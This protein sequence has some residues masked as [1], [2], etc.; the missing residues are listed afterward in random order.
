MHKSWGFGQVKTVDVVLGKMTVDFVGR[1][2]HAIDLAFAPKILTPISKDHIEARK[3]T[4]MENLKQLAALH[5]YQVIKVIIDSYDNLATSEK[6]QEVLVP[7]VIDKDDYKKWWETARR[8]MKK[9]GHFK[10]PTKKSEPIEYQDQD[11]PLQDRLLNEFNN[12]RGLKARL[13]VASE[14]TKSARD[15]EDVSVVAEKTLGKLNEEIR[16]HARTKPGLALEALMVRGDFAKALGAELAEDKFAGGQVGHQQQQQRPT[17]LFLGDAAGTEDQREEQHQRQLDHRED[18]EQ[19]AA[20]AGRVADVADLLP[21][22]DRLVGGVHQYEQSGDVAGADQK[23]PQLAGGRG[24]LAS[25]DRSGQHP[26]VLRSTRVIAEE[27]AAATA[28]LLEQPDLADLHSAVDRL[29]HVV[30]GQSGHRHR[31]QRF[32]FDTGPSLV[33]DTRLDPDGPFV[34]TGEVEPGRVERQQVTQRDQLRC[35]LGGPDAGQAGHFEDVPLVHS[36]SADPFEC[37]RFH[38]HHRLGNRHPLG[39]RLV[40]DV[41]HATGTGLVEVRQFGHRNRVRG[42][43]DGGQWL[44]SV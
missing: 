5:H 27:V 24:R 34:G 12:A 13:A 32:H 15:L 17:V 9:D 2:G 31:H 7:D 21:A 37:G 25:E 6:V 38:A 43:E 10:L 42:G 14:I 1:S 16:A 29:A 30:D 39:D 20:E 33:A 18:L 4:D 28:G 19:Q 44:A 40:P 23:V 35:P 26:L 36:A 22:E 3:S 8:E 41:D 11:I